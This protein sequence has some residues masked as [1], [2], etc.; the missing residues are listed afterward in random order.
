MLNADLAAG[1]A[2]IVY[3]VLRLWYL[4]VGA[5]QLGTAPARSPFTGSGVV[6]CFTADSCVN[7]FGLT[8]PVVCEDIPRACTSLARLAMGD[9]E[10]LCFIHGRPIMSG[11]DGI[12]RRSSFDQQ[13]DGLSTKGA[14]GEGIAYRMYERQ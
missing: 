14:I 1:L 9:F 3:R 6:M 12:F 7:Q 13:A 11:G 5:I 2:R 10:A 8:L 4:R